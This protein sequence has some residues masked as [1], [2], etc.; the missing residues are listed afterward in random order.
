MQ[1]LVV[2]EPRSPVLEAAVRYV[3]ANR[4]SGMYWFSTKQTAMVLYGLTAYM[5][6]RGETGSPAT[7][8]VSVNGDAAGAGGLRRKVDDGA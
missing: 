2:H 7:V 6:A 4:Q 8:Q 5:R 1:A 3:L